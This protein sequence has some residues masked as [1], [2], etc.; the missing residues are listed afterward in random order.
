M[1]AAREKFRLS[2]Q[3]KVLVVVLTFLVLLP[4]ITLWI[5]NA[6]ME[7]QMEDEALGTLATADSFFLKSL[8]NRSQ[9]FLTHYAS[10]ADEARFRVTA[11]LADPKTME[12]LLGSELEDSP[13]DRAALLFFNAAGELLASRRRASSIDLGRFARAADAITR[14]ALGGEKAAGVI[15]FDGNVYHVISVPVA[16]PGRGPVI[17]ALTV[18][19]HIDDATVKELKLSRTEILL[20][21][22]HQVAVATISG[23][24]LPK[25][26]VQQLASA[27][28]PV[29]ADRGRNVQSVIIAGEHFMARPGEL[30]A[31]GAAGSGLHYVM[32]SSYEQRLRDL[33]GTRRTLLGLS[34][35]GILVSA[36]VVLVCPPPHPP[37]P[38]TARQRRGGRARGFFPAH[39][40][41]FQ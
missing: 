11:G 20:A 24:E 2:L 4:A 21:V 35:A 16:A 30:D 7:Q 41:F 5:V 17:G 26:L 32:L 14:A 6:R 19:I 27:P 34:A 15:G 22:N 23:P 12:A 38:G 40:A 37:A 28:E 29:G 10:V 1:A 8:D 25:S 18:A 13:E 36:L 31:P 3:T 9:N 33:E 39:H